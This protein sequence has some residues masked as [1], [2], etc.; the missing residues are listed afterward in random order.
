MILPNNSPEP[1]P[2]GA[3]NPRSRATLI[4]SARLSYCRLGGVVHI[5]KYTL[6]FLGFVLLLTGC[7]RR[8]AKL[9]EQITGVWTNDLCVWTLSP[10][11]SW[12]S[13]IVSTNDIK[14]VGTWIVRDGFIII[15]IPPEPGR[16]SFHFLEKNRIVS[17]NKTNLVIYYGETN[18]FRRK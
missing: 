18:T 12:V 15:D 7:G 16:G 14:F 13:Q 17:V 10:D 11:G 5:M 6:L 9:T 3:V 1:S 4:G 8:D 2:N